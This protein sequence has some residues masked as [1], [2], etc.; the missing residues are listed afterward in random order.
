MKEFTPLEA[1]GKSRAML[2]SLQLPDDD[3]RGLPTSSNR[4]SDGA[5]YRVEIPSVEGPEA[6]VAV[7][8]AARAYKIRVHRVSQG[9]GIMLITHS[10]LNQMLTLG[11]EEEIEVSLFTGP[12]AGWDIGA[13]AVSTGGRGIFGCLRGAKQLLFAL[14]EV[15]HACDRGLRSILVADL[16]LLSV[17]GRLKAQG[18]LPEDLVIKVSVSLGVANPATA[19]V[20]E[21]L[22]ASTINLPVDLPLEQI[23]AIRSAVELP[24][25]VYVEGPDDHSAPVR[26]YEIPELVRVAAPV[27]L[28]FAVRN[29][30]SIYPAGAQL[31]DVVLSSARERVHRAA[32]G[33]EILERY[34]PEAVMST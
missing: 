11:R 7:V 18:D 10:E 6:L 17:L 30:P 22:G 33:L 9:S 27:Y 13:Q 3:I 24:L 21:E 15:V 23:A 20:V 4:F 34:Y 32:I 19:A 31:R 1:M 5:Q 14:E 25:D 8:E 2:R 29:S 12:R 16:G 26:H 28:K